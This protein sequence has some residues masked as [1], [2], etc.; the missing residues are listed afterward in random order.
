MNPP[1]PGSPGRSCGRTPAPGSSRAPGAEG[2]TIASTL[3][4]KAG[5]AASSAPISIPAPT[6]TECARG[7]RNSFPVAPAAHAPLASA[8]EY[9]AGMQLFSR[10]PALCIVSYLFPPYFTSRSI[11]RLS[12]SKRMGLSRM[13]SALTQA[14]SSWEE[15]SNSRPVSRV[16]AVTMMTGMEA[17][18]FLI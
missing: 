18:F 5:R 14:R 16:T 6:T 17:S 12:C 7:S 3:R 10:I 11:S 9:K 15:I 13:A 8:H 4:D 2:A 1:I